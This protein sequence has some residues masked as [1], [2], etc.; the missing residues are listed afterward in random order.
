MSEVEHQSAPQQRGDEPRRPNVV[1]V[2]LDD[3]GFG[4]CDTFGGPVETPTLDALATAGLSYNRFHTTAICSPTRASLLSGRD[5]HLTGVGTV[6]NS[7]NANPGY[8]GQLRPETASVGRVLQRNGYRTGCFGKWH[9]TPPWESSQAG[10]FDR[11]PTGQGFDRFYGF[12]GGETDQYRPTLYEGTTPVHPPASHE[13]GY[14]LT[15]DLVEQTIQWIRMGQ[16]LTP[17]RPFF[18]YLAPGA[19]HAPLQVPGPWSEKYRGAFY[20]GWDQL[21]QDTLAR[22]QASGIVPADTEL[23]PRPEEIPAWETLGEDERTVAERLMEVYAG[24]LEHT[25]VQVG[26][27]VQ[28]LRDDGLFENTLFVYVVGD[29]GSSAEG[30]PRGSMNYMGALQGIPESPESQLERLDDIGGPDS[31]AQYPAGWAWALTS[32]L[33]W[34]KQV[35]S[36][37]GG[38]RNPMVL[39]WPERIDTPGLRSQFSHVNDIVPTILEAVGIPA[40]DS[41]DGVPQLPMDGTSLVYTFGAADAPERHTTQYFEVYGHRAIYSDGWLACAHHGGVPWSVGLPGKGRP[42]EDDTWEL[43]DLRADFSQA[44]DVAETEPERLGRLQALFREEAERVGIWPLQDARVSRTPMPHLSAGRR[45][46]TYRPGVVG[47]PESEAPRMVGRSWNLQA[48]VHVADGGG[49]RGVVATMGGRA[50][51]W[52]LWV[53]DDGFPVFNYR[54]FDI[55][56]LQVRGTAALT[57]GAHVLGVDFDYEG[58]GWARP[59]T[60][61]LRVDDVDQAHGRVPVTPPMIFSIDET[62][63]IAMTFGSPVGDYPAVYPFLGGRVD[64]VDVVLR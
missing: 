42:F 44:H 60:V 27:L 54:T 58:P 59:G 18:A 7:A 46:F 19:T 31:Y 52:A 24:F 56:R 53:D 50:A 62:F 22:Q 39:T 29:N 11:W 4:A 10:P 5:A 47:V 12:L 55:A 14:H 17:D 61:T 57:P 51:G 28:A 38:T 1:V 25:D 36:H 30:G 21:R 35:A 43:Y 15:E 41:V 3:V 63:G 64:R 8:D 37:L 49:V 26:K 16:A 6:M 20:R 33:Q 32:P 13:E 40:P 45:R 48:E 2:L 23:T 9:Q 34:V